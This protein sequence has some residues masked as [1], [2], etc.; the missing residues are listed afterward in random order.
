VKNA[1]AAAQAGWGRKASMEGSGPLELA[2]AV[3]SR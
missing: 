3:A 1:A 2:D